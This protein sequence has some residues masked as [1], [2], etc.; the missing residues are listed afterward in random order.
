MVEADHKKKG[1]VLN[2]ESVPDDTNSQNAP[3]NKLIEIYLNKM[4]L[5]GIPDEMPASTRSRVKR[6]SS[7]QDGAHNDISNYIKAY[8]QLQTNRFSTSDLLSRVVKRT[9]KSVIAVAS[10]WCPSVYR[11]IQSK[12]V[13]DPVNYVYSNIMD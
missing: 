9:F 10:L 1:P 8:F 5:S 12:G 13:V 7:F 6:L 3:R 4:L 2:L 11:I